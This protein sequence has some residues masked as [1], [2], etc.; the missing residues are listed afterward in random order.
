MNQKYFDILSVKD[1]EVEKNG[2]TE[3]KTSWKTVG[4]AWASKSGENLSFELFMFPG[5]RY[6]IKLKEKESTETETQDAPF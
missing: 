2:K 4:T 6:F 5:I 3:K 1:F